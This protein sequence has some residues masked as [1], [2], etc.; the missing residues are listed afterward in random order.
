MAAAIG[1]SS[2]WPDPKAPVGRQ[3]APSAE[4]VQQSIRPFLERDQGWGYFQLP[5]DTFIEECRR[6]WGDGWGIARLGLTI[7][8]RSY[9]ELRDFPPGETDPY[10]GRRYRGPAPKLARRI[11]A[12][13]ELYPQALVDAAESVCSEEA[14][15]SVP[16]L[17]SV[18]EAQRWFDR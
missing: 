5:W 18:A 3:C 8:R 14:R 10:R 4:L 13:P 11:V 12:E 15:G 7:V 2:T 1:R 9:K 16:V 17:L 6:N